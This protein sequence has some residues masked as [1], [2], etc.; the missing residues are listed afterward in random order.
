MNGLH[1]LTAALVMVAGLCVPA[2]ADGEAELCATVC[3]SVLAQIE[4]KPD[5]PERETSA[6]GV[7]AEDNT[8]SPP[9]EPVA[10]RGLTSWELEQIESPDGQAVE[11]EHASR[12][13]LLRFVRAYSRTKPYLTADVTPRSNVWTHLQR[14]HGFMAWQLAGMTM[15]EGLWLHDAAHAGACT[16]YSTEPVEQVAQAPEDELTAAERY[17]ADGPYNQVLLFS[18]S[19]CKPCGPAKDLLPKLTEDGWSH[20]VVDVDKNRALANAF[21]VHSIPTFVVICRRQEGARY[22]GNDWPGLRAAI[23]EAV[24]ETEPP[25]A[26]DQAHTAPVSLADAL[27]A[28]SA[29]ETASN[30]Q[31]ALPG[32]TVA[33]SRLVEKHRGSALEIADGVTLHIPEGLTWTSRREGDA[34]VLDFKPHV[35]ATVRKL[36]DWSA[37]LE[38]LVVR[39]DSVTLGLD[40]LPDVEVG[41]AW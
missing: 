38:S 2:R 3:A 9:R 26:A 21:E 20:K 25:Q 27:V 33:V 13:E 18:A 4:L 17:I 40:N 24:D 7:P 28:A 39:V 37:S 30:V 1:R 5:L 16:P 11:A 19:W 6:P 41:I 15:D 12:D 31:A 22:T 34:V 14:E 10:L 32:P 23:Q 35:R 29:G 36:V 8:P